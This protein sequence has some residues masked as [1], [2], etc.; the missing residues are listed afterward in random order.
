MFYDNVPSS[1]LNIDYSSNFLFAYQINPKAINE[2]SIPQVSEE[3][4]KETIQI[5]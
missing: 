1:M 2:N 3:E 5:E 4:K